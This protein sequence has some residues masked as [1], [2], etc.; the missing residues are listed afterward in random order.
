LRSRPSSR[1]RHFNLSVIPAQAGIQRLQ[2]T[3][4]SIF[5]PPATLIDFADY[6]RILRLRANLTKT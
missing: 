6:R 5:S 2:R 4:I 3:S 1:N